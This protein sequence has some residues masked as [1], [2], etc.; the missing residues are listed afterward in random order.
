MVDVKKDE[1]IFDL[2][3][4]IELLPDCRDIRAWDSL[5]YA[6]YTISWTKTYYETDQTRT[7]LKLSGQDEKRE[8]V[9]T[10]AF[11]NAFICSARHHLGAPDESWMNPIA[12]S[13][14]N[15]TVSDETIKLFNELGWEERCR[16][17]I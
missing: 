2:I 10:A 12:R 13:R 11:A 3:T 7:L 8:N 16:I 14:G 17:N 4:N 9:Y 5:F 15:A 1:L 6:L